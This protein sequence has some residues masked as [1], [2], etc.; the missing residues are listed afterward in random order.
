MTTGPRGNSS[1]SLGGAMRLAAFREP[2][3][4]IF[5][6]CFL[7]WPGAAWG[8]SLCLAHPGIES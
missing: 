2:Y 5:P 4:C 8:H 3:W 6:V 1:R 7:A